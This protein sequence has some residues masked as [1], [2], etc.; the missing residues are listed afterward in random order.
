MTDQTAS[1]RSA[2]SPRIFAGTRPAR[3]R[4]FG[5]DK[6]A[7]VAIEFAIIAPVMLLLVSMILNIALM[8]LVGAMLDAGVNSL[9][10]GIRVG[11]YTSSNMSLSSAKSYLCNSIYNVMNCS[12]NLKLSV[13]TVS[14]VGLQ[15]PPTPVQNGVFSMAE[16]FNPGGSSSYVVIYAFFQWP[17]FYM[18]YGQ[19]MLANG[20]YLIGAATLFENE[21]F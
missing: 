17:V 7:S 11:T 12:A 15:T 20:S 16:G 3:R 5:P 14:T 9:G 2:L 10:R 6:K 18:A 21:P 1:S 19:G 13:Q 8:Y 4:Y